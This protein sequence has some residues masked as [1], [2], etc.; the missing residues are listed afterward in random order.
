MALSKTNSSSE[1]QM[2]Q[3][4]LSQPQRH[5]HFVAPCVSS[6]SSPVSLM[7]VLPTGDSDF[8]QQRKTKRLYYKI[9]G[10]APNR[11]HVIHKHRQQWSIKCGNMVIQRTFQLSLHRLPSLLTPGES[12]CSRKCEGTGTR[13]PFPA[14]RL[15]NKA[16]PPPNLK[17]TKESGL[18]EA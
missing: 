9:L 16:F 11:C 2:K 8:T 14:T 15:R 1:T 13:E 6:P 17:E 10:P 12:I 18:M 3:S 5:A 7:D 4:K